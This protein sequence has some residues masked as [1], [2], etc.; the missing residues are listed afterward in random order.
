MILSLPLL[1][2]LLLTTLSFALPMPDR[3]PHG[4]PS[5]GARPWFSREDR[6]HMNIVVDRH[7]LFIECMSKRTGGESEARRTCKEFHETNDKRVDYESDSELVGPSVHSSTEE[8]RREVS[9]DRP[10]QSDQTLDTFQQFD[11]SR[12][13]ISSNPSDL[14]STTATESFSTGTNAEQQDERF[15]TMPI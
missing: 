12:E 14:T 6:S 10:T 11:T 5:D 8:T 15:P 13:E 7:S 9:R 4:K 1:H 2:L 3:I